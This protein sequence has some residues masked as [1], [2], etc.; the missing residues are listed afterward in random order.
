[1]SSE[2][3]AL[4]QLQ[5][6]CREVV[7]FVGA[8]WLS[9]LLWGLGCC[10]LAL[11]GSSRQQYSSRC[12]WGAACGAACPPLCASPACPRSSM[13]LQASLRSSL[14]PCSQYLLL[15]GAVLRR[16]RQLVQAAAGGQPHG[17][18]AAAPART[19]PPGSG[20]DGGCPGDSG[21]GAPEILLTV[22]EHVVGGF[23]VVGLAA[24][25]GV[26]RRRAPAACLCRQPA[27][28]P[29][30]HPSSLPLGPAATSPT[31]VRG[32]P[33]SG[34]PPPNAATAGHLWAIPM[35]SSASA[36]VRLCQLPWPAPPPSPDASR[37]KQAACRPPARRPAISS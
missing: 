20:C 24:C 32:A 8:A 2:L 37:H 11:S 16:Q 10:V 30:S 31:R 36:A 17:G 35:A 1:M 21:D 7:V 28:Q 19:D 14:L 3:A 5:V 4:E 27:K 34:P 26:L 25:A 12:I 18:D 33:G 6:R 13:R 22:N 15:L 9:M 29:A 23:Q